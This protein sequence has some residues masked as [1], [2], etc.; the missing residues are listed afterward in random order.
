MNLLE[1]TEPVFQYVCRLNR[2]ARKGATIDYETVRSDVR[3]LFAQ[4]A[5]K[6]RSD[7]RLAQQYQKIELPLTFFIDSIV[8]ESRL[9]FAM[10]W[11]QNRLAFDRQ[12]LAGDE[13]FFEL[14]EETLAERGDEA[15]ERLAVYYT[16]LGLGF[17]GWYSGQ[18]DVLKRK[19]IDLA[20]RIRSYVESD[21]TA[22][23]CPDAYE[24]TDDR[25]FALPP[26]SRLI[27]WII[28]I[29]VLIIAVGVV[30]W[31]SFRSSSADLHRSLEAIVQH[32]PAAPAQPK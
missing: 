26:S 12:E 8:S 17:S 27:P 16:C 13:R 19:M 31:D 10:E 2:V 11:N 5:D 28:A 29:G 1:L 18:P 25:N 9:H 22:R 23:I 6:S 30:Y 14:L 4:M 20:P 7:A 21:D 15:A 32:D 3:E 24:H